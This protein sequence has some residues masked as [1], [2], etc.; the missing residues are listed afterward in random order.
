VF[1]WNVEGFEIVVF[2]F[3]LGTVGGGEAEAAHDVF[4]LFD[5]LGD[6]V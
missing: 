1:L 2:V 5:R 3:D 4:Q 6:G